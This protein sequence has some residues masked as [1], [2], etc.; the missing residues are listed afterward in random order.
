[1]ASFQVHRGA[2]A[3][4]SPWLQS[5]QAPALMQTAIPQA[6]VSPAFASA[7]A[8]FRM[9]SGA[10]VRAVPLPHPGY[11]QPPFGGPLLLDRA[12]DV[13]MRNATEARQR[14]RSILESKRWP[15]GP[16][17]RRHLGRRRAPQ[18]EPRLRGNGG[19][20]LQAGASQADA[21]VAS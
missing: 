2:P 15:Y 10:P 4:A 9:R 21:P 5:E 3:D 16:K 17:L 20:I 7:M 11:S 12:A 8:S 18:D 6:P 1:M 19:W 14:R 13:T